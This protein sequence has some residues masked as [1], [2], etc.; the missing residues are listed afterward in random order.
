MDEFQSHTNIRWRGHVGTVEYGGGDTSMVVLFFNKAVHN[1][2]KSKEAGCPQ[3]DDVTFVRIHPPGERLNIVERKVQD[4]DK[5]RWP[6]QWHQFI[7]QREQIPEGTPVDLLYPEYP[8]VAAML[9]A[10]GVH[11]V[12]QLS[13]LSANAIE[14]IGMGAQRY[15]NEAKAYLDKAEKGVG[16]AQLRQMEEAHER[17]VASLRKEIDMLKEQVNL[18]ANNNQQITQDQILNMVAQ[19]M[20][21]PVHLPNKAF[22]PQLAQINAQKDERANPRVRRKMKS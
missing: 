11:T 6:V 9:R 14:T 3:Y 22:D 13:E 19:A 17:E 12:Q 21:R 16:A 2:L 15:V 8:S 18:V 4:S 1:P 10:S 20:G 5:R 7:D